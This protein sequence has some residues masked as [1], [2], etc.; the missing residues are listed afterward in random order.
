MV[1]FS[2]ARLCPSQTAHCQG[3]N[4]VPRH[5]PHQGHTQLCPG[6]T[7]KSCSLRPCPRTSVDTNTL[8]VTEMCW[9]APGHY[10]RI[11]HM[12][13]LHPCSHILTRC[14]SSLLRVCTMGN[15]DIKSLQTSVRCDILYVEAGKLSRDC[16]TFRSKTLGNAV[17]RRNGDGEKK[18]GKQQASRSL[19]VTSLRGQ[20]GDQP[21]C[22][23][24]SFLFLSLIF[25]A[26]VR[27]PNR[28]FTT[29]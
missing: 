25:V 18:R 4:H 7:K 28:A 15:A 10:C 3:W 6:G 29:Q 22:C 8:A 19:I 17:Q 23:F 14:A 13:G 16:I 11:H 24:E 21:T 12:A 5:I 2:R 27:E 1:C 9:I 26:F 20:P